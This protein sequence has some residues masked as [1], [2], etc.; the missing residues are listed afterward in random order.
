[1]VVRSHLADHAESTV[2]AD[3]ESDPCLTT[4]AGPVCSTGMTWMNGYQ[5][6]THLHIRRR[7][8]ESDSLVQQGQARAGQAGMAGLFC[9]PA[10]S[11]LY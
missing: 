10:L 5:V 4:E 1:V 9:R 8:E 3:P 7:A 11:I 2:V 6:P